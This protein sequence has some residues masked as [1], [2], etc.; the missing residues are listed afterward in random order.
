MVRLIKCLFFTILLFII[1]VAPVLAKDYSFPQVSF[2]VHLQPDGS[3]QVE[4]K[5]TYNFNGSFSWADEYIK[6]KSQ[7]SKVKNYQITNVQVGDENGMYHRRKLLALTMLPT[8]PIK[9]ISNGSIRPPA[10][11]KLL[12]LLIQLPMQ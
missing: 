3:A 12:P 7:N 5:R 8:N 9:L 11:L 10:P 4:E 1:S 2:L 6:V